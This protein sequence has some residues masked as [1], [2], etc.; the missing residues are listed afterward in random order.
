MGT[1]EVIVA[2]RKEKCIHYL[3]VLEDNSSFM[4]PEIRWAL[5]FAIELLKNCPEIQDE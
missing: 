1:Y 3:R 4:Q 2:N 5:K